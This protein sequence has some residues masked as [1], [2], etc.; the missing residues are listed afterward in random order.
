VLVASSAV[1]SPYLRCPV[2]Q[3]HGVRERSGGEWVLAGREKR[4]PVSMGP[5]L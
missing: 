3:G 5:I 1:A 4:W 2:G